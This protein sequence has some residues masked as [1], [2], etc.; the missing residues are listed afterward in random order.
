MRNFR[1]NVFAEKG[2]KQVPFNGLVYSCFN[3]DCHGQN[4]MS[5]LS[6]NAMDINNYCNCVTLERG[7]VGCGDWKWRRVNSGGLLWDW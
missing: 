5:S 3:I 2:K 6:W 4:I 7:T 1:L